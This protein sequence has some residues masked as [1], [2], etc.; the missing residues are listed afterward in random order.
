MKIEREQKLIMK[1]SKKKSE[2]KPKETKAVKKPALFDFLNNI[3]D[4][5]KGQN[6]LQNTTAFV[7]ESN[8]DSDDKGYV[9]FMINRGLSY[10]IDTVLYAN[11]MNERS[12]IPSKMQ[13]DFYR[14][15]L[16]PRKRFS[17]WFK[18]EDDTEILEIIK[19]EYGYSSIKAREALSLFTAEAIDN[20]RKKH[21]K[22]GKGKTK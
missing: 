16:R 21:D 2:D 4:G 11:A 8:P 12:H 6:L 15:S 1:T 14:H 9:S 18:A 22:G 5:S 19:S 7:E 3:N 20:L 17:K 10:Y 13:Y